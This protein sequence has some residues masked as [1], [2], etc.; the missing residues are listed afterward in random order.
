M[1][2][3]GGSALGAFDMSCREHLLDCRKSSVPSE[4]DESLEVLGPVGPDF[5]LE[6]K[7]FKAASA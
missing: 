5:L 1:F 3:P 2:V 6:D 4:D 7:V